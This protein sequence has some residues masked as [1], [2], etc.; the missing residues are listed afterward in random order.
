MQKRMIEFIRALRAAG[1]RISLAESQDAMFG[2]DH[3]G[4]QNGAIFKSALK[5]TLVKDHRQQPV[6]DYFFPLFFKDNRPPLQNIL[7]DMSED[8]KALLGEAM[9]AL[10]N[11][12]DALRDLLKR[13]LE[14]R[15]FSDDE[16]RQMAERAGLPQGEDMYT[17]PGSSGA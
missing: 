1:V 17:R 13:L 6:F 12:M 15:D 9:R 2:V 11:E 5:S 14:G 7:E 10:M 16:L 3:G 8:D 4:V